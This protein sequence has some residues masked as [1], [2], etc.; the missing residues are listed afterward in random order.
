MSNRCKSFLA[1]N[2]GLRSRFTNVLR[3]PDYTAE[4]SARIF[5][6][7]AKEQG[8]KIDRG[9]NV[10]LSKLLADLISAPHWSNGRDVRTLLEFSL[11][12][13][14]RRLA[15]G[16]SSEA[17]ILKLADVSLALESMLQNKWAGG[18]RNNDT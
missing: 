11:R 3:L 5:L 14:G 2:P 1:S 9:L 6:N 12:A 17:D 18:A 16:G 7:M 10:K 4:E 8:L 13:Q 15:K